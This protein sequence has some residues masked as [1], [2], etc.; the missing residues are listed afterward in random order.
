MKKGLIFILLIPTLCFAQSEIILSG[1]NQSNIEQAI[2]DFNNSN[3][4][5]GTITIKGNILIQQNLNI[6]SKVTLNILTGNK[7]IVSNGKS[8]E[9]KGQVLSTTSQ[10][11]ETTTE[12]HN[13]RI[14]N[15]SVYPEWF[16]LISYQDS[17]ITDD[18]PTIQKAINSL[19]TGGEIIFNGNQYLIGAVINITTAS[20]TLKGKRTYFAGLDN[21]N[22]FIAIN[23]NVPSMFLVGEYGV[24]FNDLNF[25]G[26]IPNFSSDNANNNINNHTKGENTINKAISFIRT[27]NS[28][29]LDGEVTGC[30]FKNFKHC[31]YGRG[32]NLNIIENTFT[33]SYNGVYI[34]GAQHI[35]QN[36][37]LARTRGHRILKNRFHSLGG[38]SKHITLVGSNCIKI[39]AEPY[40]NFGVVS[41]TYTVRGFYNEISDNY[42]DDCKTFFE[43]IIDRTK[44]DGNLILYSGGTAI[45]ATGGLYGTIINNIIDGSH[46]F[47]PHKLYPFK[48]CNDNSDN[49]CDTFNFPSGHG[50]HIQYA[51]NSTI[52][53]NQ[54]LNKRFHGIYLERS[55][56][57]S[58]QSNTIRNFNR[59]SYIKISGKNPE[60]NDPIL[61]SGIHIENIEN[62]SYNIQ[63]IVANN[64]ISITHTGIQARYGIYAGDGDNDNFI[65]NNF[66]L[67]V[68][69][70]DK[71]KIEN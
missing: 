4:G 20:I 17:S 49:E 69:L 29:D 33:A 46:T 37:H 25:E 23:N 39:E 58:I 11:F 65:K 53:N 71:I 60:N 48:D 31:I 24:R 56:N 12:N 27:N 51:H 19:V 28:K 5:Y 15:Q 26:Y 9:I 38:S 64:T 35:D 32:A 7:F 68:R 67:P 18:K 1:G 22:N 62:T 55:K 3:N 63:N 57:S 10:I 8:L 36:K 2:T 52:H 41:E 44:I 6:P 50:I 43:G 14:F 66:I 13:I 42:S 70:I 47:N 61:Y 40:T 59:H 21:T 34:Q 30:S 54:I 16:G 45:K